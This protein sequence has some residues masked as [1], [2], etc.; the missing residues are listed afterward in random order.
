[1][2]SRRSISG[3]VLCCAMVVGAIAVLALVTIYDPDHA[4]KCVSEFSVRWLG[5]AM[6]VHETLAAGLLAAIGAL[7]GAWLAFSAVQDQIGM[8]KE[9]ERE[10]AR[11]KA[12]RQMQEVYR[13]IDQLGAAKQFISLM[14]QSFPQGVSSREL[15]EQLLRFRRGGRLD[16][17][18]S[19]F[20]DAP[21]GIADS[22]AAIM[23]QLRTIADNLYDEIKGLEASSRAA[24]VERTGSEI[25][26][27]IENLGR[28]S[29]IID[30]RMPAYKARFEDARRT[31]QS[32]RLMP[33]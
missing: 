5:C 24:T 31:A 30:K 19:L 17:T 28:I 33:Q 14:V 11:L 4:R 9:N 7:L 26:F 20:A 16:M 8:A 29:D 22:I 23:T 12:E 25:P 10:A 2:T 3:V 13:E 18:H 32:G 15:G 21:E 1:M 6:A 27:R